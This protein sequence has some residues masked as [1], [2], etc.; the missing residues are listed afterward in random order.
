MCN[1]E[2]RICVTRVY[3][4]AIPTSRAIDVCTIHV[5]STNFKRMHPRVLS[6]YTANCKN[7]VYV[8]LAFFLRDEML[9]KEVLIAKI[10]Y[11]YWSSLS[12]NENPRSFTN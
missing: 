6:L 5:Y 7:A 4:V 8:R 10:L 1:G 11:F 12:N 3:H 9:L 2:Q